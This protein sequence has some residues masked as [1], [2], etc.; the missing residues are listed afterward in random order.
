MSGNATEVSTAQYG[1]EVS[2]QFNTIEITDGLAVEVIEESG[3][4]VEIDVS[5][6]LIE[7]SPAPVTELILEEQVVGIEVIQQL[8]INNP[9]VDPPTEDADSLTCSL[10][11][12]ENITVNKAVYLMAD[13]RIGLADKDDPVKYCAII[14][15]SRQAGATGQFIDVVKFGKLTGFTSG[16]PGTEYYLGD[17]GA[18]ETTPAISGAWLFI[19]K[20]LESNALLVNIGEPIIRA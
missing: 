17:N 8:V 18:L 13:G 5:S 11:C 16:T 2:G 15:V 10:E 19:G 4:V 20:Q 3:N 1:L 7:I 9:D 14:G 6:A 12:G